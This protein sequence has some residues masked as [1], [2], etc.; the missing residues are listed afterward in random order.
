MH[1][2]WTLEDLHRLEA[3]VIDSALGDDNPGV[4]ENAIQ[5]AEL[6]LRSNPSLAARLLSMRRDPHPRV[7]LQLLFTL[8]G[9]GTAAAAAVRH[10]LLIED[11]E[12]EWM[13]V[14]ALS[15]AGSNPQELWQA[16]VDRLP[17]P[18]T[19][20]RRALFGKIGAGAG[21]TKPARAAQ[22]I[23]HAVAARGAPPPPPPTQGAAA[24]PGGPTPPRPHP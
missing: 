11:V 9:L 14:A 23:L 20:A 16:A 6:H 3:G 18:E 7:R 24:P 15:A 19:P 5:L 13:Q 1:A 22:E 8:G 10:R 17:A 12:D 2:L 4:R 21:A